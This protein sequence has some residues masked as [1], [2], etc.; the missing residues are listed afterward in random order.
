MSADALHNGCAI[1]SDGLN[2]EL[3][4]CDGGRRLL[5][6]VRDGGLE[7]I[8]NDH[9]ALLT[10]AEDREN[11]NG[12]VYGLTAHKVSDHAEF[13]YAVTDVLNFSNSFHRLLSSCRCGSRS[14]S[15]F[16]LAVTAE[17]T[18]R[19]KF[20]ELVTDHV[21][22]HINR[23]ELLPV[24]H[25]EGQTDHVRNDGGTAGPSLDEL[26][27]VRTNHSL[28]LVQNVGIHESTFLKGSRH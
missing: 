3:G 1:G 2:L 14:D 7:R 13:T 28:G 26:F 19:G 12:F 23:K 24:V 9:G 8:F 15:R 21:F 17:D 18:G 16:S 27:L 25:G 5:L 6:E 4:G 10:A 22:S 20:T 11:G